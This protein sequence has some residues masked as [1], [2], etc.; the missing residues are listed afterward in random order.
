MA[1]KKQFSQVCAATSKIVERIN[2]S[3]SIG[4]LDQADAEMF[5]RTMAARI[6]LKYGVVPLAILSDHPPHCYFLDQ[7]ILSMG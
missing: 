4:Q 2:C 5:T 6:L 3:S 7:R 1:T